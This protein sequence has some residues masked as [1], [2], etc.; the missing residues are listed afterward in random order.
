MQEY[1]SFELFAHHKGFFLV[2]FCQSPRQGIKMAEGNCEC[3]RSI[4]RCLKCD[5]LQFFTQF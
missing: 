3:Y 4:A 2:N 5:A 1:L